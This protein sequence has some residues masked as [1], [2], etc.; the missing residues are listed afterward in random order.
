MD[1][2]LLKNILEAGLLVAAKPMTVAQL[3]GLF[4]DDTDKPNRAD[5]K[6]AL[7]ELQKEY[8][9]RGIELV[10]IASGYR[11][12]SRDSMAHWMARLFDER[13]P[14]YS[15]ALLETLVL[16][17]YRQPITRGEIEEIRG[18]AVSSNIVKTLLERQWVKEVGHKD[19]PGKPALLGTTKH[20]LDY[21]N[22]KRLDDLPPLGEIKDL[23]QIDAV[24]AESMGIENIDGADQE[25]A[26]NDDVVV[27]S[28]DVDISLEDASVEQTVSAE[29]PVNESSAEP[30]ELDGSEGI[31]EADSAQSDDVGDDTDDLHIEPSE[32]GDDN[33]PIQGDGGD[34]DP[35]AIEEGELGFDETTAESEL[36][37]VIADFAD[38][39]QQELDAQRQLDARQ[40][41]KPI[42]DSGQQADENSGDS[43]Q[44]LEEVLETEGAD[45]ASSSASE[46]TSF[47]PSSSSEIADELP[48]PNDTLH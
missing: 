9:G 47:Q 41:S 10:E 4:A 20:F 39:H 7:I 17:A 48:K 8:E 18:V 13:L 40:L 28:T 2:Q 19:V 45:A 5:I 6:E 34:G 42:E 3:D 22:L 11:L 32:S 25:P 36:K 1:A 27:K 29:Q 44:G 37:R 16:V 23:D 24:L 43:V 31:I 14:R 33:S 46:K 35:T 30:D 12:Q 38:E 26:A 15:R 21:F